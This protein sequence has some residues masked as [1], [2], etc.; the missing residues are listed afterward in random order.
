MELIGG[1][2][3]GHSF[4]GCVDRNGTRVVDKFKNKFFTI[5]FSRYLVLSYT[6]VI[7][8]LY[9]GYINYSNLDSDI[10]NTNKPKIVIIDPNK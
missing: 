1:D 8:K 4:E 2:F 3:H 9:F 6:L 7:L 10:L 5:S